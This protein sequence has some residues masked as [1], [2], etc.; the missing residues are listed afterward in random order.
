MQ[1]EL[2]ANDVVTLDL[3]SQGRLYGKSQITDYIFRGDDLAD[4]N[5]V[6]YFTDTY[7]SAKRADDHPKGK[8]GTVNDRFRF[9]KIT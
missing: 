4:Y 9:L 3:N 2:Q 6:Q 5:I 1:D 8:A 7:E